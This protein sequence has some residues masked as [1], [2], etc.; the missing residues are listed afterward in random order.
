MASRRN[1]QERERETLVNTRITVLLKRKLIPGGLRAKNEFADF[2]SL[3]P[4]AVL[5]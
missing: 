3:F 2:F 4:Q 5:A 1:G